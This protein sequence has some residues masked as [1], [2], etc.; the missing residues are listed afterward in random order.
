MIAAIGVKIVCA[1][2]TDHALN[3]IQVISDRNVSS[4]AAAKPL[5]VKNVLVKTQLILF[6]QYAMLDF[7]HL[8]DD[9]VFAVGVV[10]HTYSRNVTAKQELALEVA[11]A[12]GMERGAI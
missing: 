6:V 5:T 8:A 9:A 3:V 7:T 2:E 4:I 1:T 10:M 11:K 12:D